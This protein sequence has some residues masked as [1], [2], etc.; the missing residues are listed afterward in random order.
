MA[1]LMMPSECTAFAANIKGLADAPEHNT[2]SI[3]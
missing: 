2:D 3:A 1:K